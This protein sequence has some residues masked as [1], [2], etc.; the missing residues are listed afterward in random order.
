MNSVYVCSMDTSII[1]KPERWLV[2]CEHAA[3]RVPEK[4]SA[5]FTEFRNELNSHRG[6]DPG[7][8]ELAN[9]I[10]DE[11]GIKAHHFPYT[12]LLIEPNRSLSHPQL[13]S[14]V[15]R[16][17]SRTDKQ[18]LI[19][20]YYNPYR[21]KIKQSIKVAAKK[22]IQ[23]IHLSIH[24]FTPI[25]KEI[26]RHIDIGILY[27]PVREPEKRF[28]LTWQRKLQKLLPSFNIRRNRPY[29]GSADGLTTS[30][31]RLFDMQHYLGIELEVSQK[32]IMGNREEWQN[33]CRLIVKSLDNIQ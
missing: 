24:T 4:Y 2:T 3:N 8:A 13:F 15:S 33:I 25:W 17:L 28:C 27:D 30:L 14:K 5:L 11:L 32:F 26:E 18:H 1:Y 31:R 23:T 21:V 22:N 7:A 16:G 20:Q 9:K 10:A 19:D 29:K 12:R 6:W